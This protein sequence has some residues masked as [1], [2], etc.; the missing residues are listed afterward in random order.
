[1]RRE[2]RGIR[3]GG[4]CA[5]YD[6]R[7]FSGYPLIDKRSSLTH[8]QH[9]DP[10]CSRLHIPHLFPSPLPTSASSS[11]ISSRTRKRLCRQV[12]RRVMR[13][14]CRLSCR[15]CGRVPDHCGG[16]DHSCRCPD[17]IRQSICPRAC[18]LGIR[19][20][21]I[22]VRCRHRLECCWSGRR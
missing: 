19:K 14:R 3:P 1:M 5:A 20:R 15:F 22:D 8:R 2:N 21:S 18:M 10:C 9:W 4:L 13:G 16:T 7:N 6:W 11:C 17:G 12:R